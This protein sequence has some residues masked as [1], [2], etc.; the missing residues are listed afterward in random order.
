PPQ[1]L[2]RGARGPRDRGRAG[3]A[4]DRGRAAGRVLRARPG[5][6]ELRP[7]RD[8]RLDRQAAAPRRRTLPEEGRGARDLP[9]VRGSLPE[10]HVPRE[11]TV[12]RLL[13]A[14]ATVVVALEPAA[15]AATPA[16]P[17]PTPTR[18]LQVG[19]FQA[20]PWAI[21]EPNGEWRGLT[22]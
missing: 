11:M 19:V 9:R 22:V 21:K 7:D 12:R 14:L 20:P 13:T 15:R 10:I 4:E 2:R 5:V 8:P 6:H 16:P 3:P 1:P 18:V 17:K